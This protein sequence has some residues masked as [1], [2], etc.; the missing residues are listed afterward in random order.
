MIEYKQ[1]AIV[2]E[3]RRRIQEGI[4]TSLLPTTAE[5]AAEFGVNV[6]T[7]GKA[8]ARLVAEGRLERRRHSGTRLPVQEKRN[9]A[10]LIEIIF[11]GYTSVFT[12]PFW[13]EIWSGIVE[14][15]SREAFRP[16][17]NMLEA[18]RATGLLKLAGFTMCPSAG[19]IVL[20]IAEPRLF[21]AVRSSGVPFLAAG[22]P[23]EDPAVPQVAFDFT[24]GIR[25]AVDHLEQLGCRRIAFIGQTRSF[26]S[27]AQLGKFHAYLKAVQHHRQVDPE[28]IEDVRPLSGLGAPALAAL[29]KRSVPDAVIAAYDHQLPEMLA[30]LEERRLAIPVIGCDGLKLAGLPP[31]RHTVAAPLSECGREAA[32]RLLAA[33]SEKHS[34]KSLFLEARFR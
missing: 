32:R 9:G 30:W 19:K 14:E 26:I 1:P 18:D 28:L 21:E 31:D 13:G 16:V 33:I 20:G 23:V 25:Q 27:P 4:Y 6:K 8:I 24:R 29:L 11:E 15:L 34:A 7:M 5:L 2:A 10:E 17:L 22:D 12:H 3:L